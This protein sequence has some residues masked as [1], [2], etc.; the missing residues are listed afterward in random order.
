MNTRAK[1]N[2]TLLKEVWILQVKKLPSRE[3]IHVGKWARVIIILNFL[4]LFLGSGYKSSNV[5][6]LFS[7]RNPNNMQPF[8]CPIINGKNGYAIICT[9]SYG[10]LFGGSDLHI[11]NNANTI[12]G[13]YSNLGN[14]YQPPAGYQYNTPQTQSLFAG[15][16][17][18]TPTEIEV[19]Y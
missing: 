4:I 16:Y 19:F 18:F 15:S 8:K 7:L 12:Q 1:S 3:Q 11:V 17:K 6:F 5:S 9:P 2:Y 14:T 13:S 10:A